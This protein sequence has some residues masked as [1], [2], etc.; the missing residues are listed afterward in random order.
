MPIVWAG[1]VILVTGL[2]I[3]FF[4]SHRRIWI[5]AENH[6]SGVRVRVAGMANRDPVGLR[7]HLLKL[8]DD[9]RKYVL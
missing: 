1:C 5:R 2:F 7:R 9:L 4:M 3:T 8:T 6:K